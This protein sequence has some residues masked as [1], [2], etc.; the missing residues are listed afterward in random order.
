MKQ[1]ISESVLDSK[2]TSSSSSEKTHLHNHMAH[3]VFRNCVLAGRNKVGIF[4][5]FQDAGS[6]DFVTDYVM[7]RMP[8][9]I[10]TQ[11]LNAPL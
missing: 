10:H 7:T 8:R 11:V 1:I 4:L 5:H 3:S 9:H 2:P 6:V